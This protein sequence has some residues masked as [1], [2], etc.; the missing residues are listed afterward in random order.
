MGYSNMARCRQYPPVTSEALPVLVHNIIQ[1][2][3][4]AAVT[5]GQ[6]GGLSFSIQGRAVLL[7]GL[8][9]YK[10]PGNLGKM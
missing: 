3:G 7:K 4:L 10:L 6:V 1:G 5:T 2:A 9:A 8:S